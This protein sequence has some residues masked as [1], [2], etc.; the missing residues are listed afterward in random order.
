MEV[1]SNKNCP[2]NKILNPKTN[3]CVAINGK[4]GKNIITKDI[5]DKILNPKTNRYVNIQ[6]EIY[7]GINIPDQ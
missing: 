5:N 3:R 2:I 4:I 6:D 1:K 7:P